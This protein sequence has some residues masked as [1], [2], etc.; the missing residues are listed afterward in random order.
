MRLLRVVQAQGQIVAVVIRKRAHA[1]EEERGGDDAYKHRRHDLARSP[2]EAADCVNA[3]HE[4]AVLGFLDPAAEHEKQAR[5]EQEHRQHRDKYGFNEH[6]AEVAAE[7]ELHER[8]GDKAAYGR[9]R[10][11]RDLGYCL[12]KRLYR[13][14]VGLKMPPLLCK[15]VAQDNSVVYRKRELQNERHGVCD[16]RYLFKQ[17]VRALL[18]GR[19]HREG[20][21]Q[22]RHLGIAARGDKQQN[23]DRHDAQCAYNEHL[24]QK[25]TAE[26]RADL[27]VKLHIV[28]IIPVRDEGV[29]V[30]KGFFAQL[31]VRRSGKAHRYERRA[32]FIVL[33]GI[34]KARRAHAAKLRYLL[35][36]LERTVIRCVLDHQVSRCVG[37]K[38]AL[39]GLQAAA[40]LR[41]LREKVKKVVFD[42]REL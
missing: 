36:K 16:I 42:R 21:E 15:A 2:G 35:R 13:R 30:L 25:L 4:A 18:Q 1:R 10:R 41:F 9:K 7:A 32:V 34:V 23:Y 31:V 8:H 29:H 37:Y 40:R 17:E 28:G 11:R 38:L 14:V 5:H 20:Y 33:L 39:H 6:L 12:G 22:H 27:G 19:R 24:A 26:V 3:R